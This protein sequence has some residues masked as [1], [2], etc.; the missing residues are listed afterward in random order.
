M[1]PENGRGSD[2]NRPLLETH[3]RQFTCDRRYITFDVLRL[4]DLAGKEI[5]SEG[6]VVTVPSE[7]STE[8]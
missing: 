3:A 2:G 1:P 8:A 4:F 6:P 7:L 5:S